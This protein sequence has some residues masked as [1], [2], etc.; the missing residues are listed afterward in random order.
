M[1]TIQLRRA[2]TRICDRESAPLRVDV[3]DDGDVVPS[4]WA[5]YTRNFNR[6]TGLDDSTRVSLRIESWSGTLNSI[7]FNHEA[8]AIGN[9]PLLI[10]ITRKLRPHNQLRI[11]IANNDQ[12]AGRLDGGVA[13]MI[14]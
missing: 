2:W 13:L 9:S 11:R 6:P 10:D 12:S 4:N 1:H 8:L 7:S 5:E 3:P 14:E